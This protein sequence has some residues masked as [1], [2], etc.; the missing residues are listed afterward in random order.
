LAPFLDYAGHNTNYINQPDGAWRALAA[1]S[2][3]SKVLARVLCCGK[4]KAR[5]LTAG[6]LWP[7]KDPG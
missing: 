7:R 5:G 4:R 3:T 1:R 6:G 2:M